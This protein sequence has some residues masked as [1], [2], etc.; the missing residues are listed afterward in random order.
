[1]QLQDDTGV[2]DGPMSEIRI[3]ADS[4]LEL[5]DPAL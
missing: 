2:G 1:M 5:S 4:W 3:A